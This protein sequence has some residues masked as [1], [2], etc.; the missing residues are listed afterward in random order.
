MEINNQLTSQVSEFILN[1]NHVSISKL[2][3]ALST[4]QK[5]IHSKLTSVST[6]ISY[7]LFTNTEWLFADDKIT[8][9]WNLRFS[10]RANNE[11]VC[12]LRKNR[13]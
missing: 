10:V 11:G 6:L 1:T 9:V 7:D 12:A 5:Q 8:F 3:K 2:H 4:D 13:Q